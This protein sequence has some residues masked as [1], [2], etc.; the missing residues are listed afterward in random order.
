MIIISMLIELKELNTFK[1]Q[2]QVEFMNDWMFLQ[3]DEAR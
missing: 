1:R 3:M 2:K